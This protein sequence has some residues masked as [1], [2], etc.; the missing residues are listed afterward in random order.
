[1]DGA[2]APAINEAQTHAMKPREKRRRSGWFLRC[3]GPLADRGSRGG[4]GTSA[5]E[6]SNVRS[7]GAPTPSP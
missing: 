1:M 3:E 6:R 7:M 2:H 5:R 4:A